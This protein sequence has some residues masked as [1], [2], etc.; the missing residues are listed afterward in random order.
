MEL[1]LLKILTNHLQY[2][3]HCFLEVTNNFKA[4]VM[5]KQ[6]AS[7]NYTCSCFILKKTYE[8]LT[9]TESL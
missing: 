6:D 8:I 7:Q 1:G 9:W 5:V 4:M 2:A 3:D